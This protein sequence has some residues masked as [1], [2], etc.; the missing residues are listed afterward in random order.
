MV[1]LLLLKKACPLIL[2]DKWASLYRKLIIQTV[3]INDDVTVFTM[4]YYAYT[5]L[6]HN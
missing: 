1:K 3:Y 6:L 5:S 4:A 2:Y